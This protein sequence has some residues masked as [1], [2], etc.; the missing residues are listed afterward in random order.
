MSFWK[1]KQALGSKVYIPGTPEKMVSLLLASY[2]EYPFLGYLKEG[3][4]KVRKFDPLNLPETKASIDVDKL[5][6]MFTCG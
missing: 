4:E 3:K 5:R 6:Y 1:G 2:S